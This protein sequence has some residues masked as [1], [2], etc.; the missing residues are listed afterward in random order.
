[1]SLLKCYSGRP[2][3][4]V[5]LSD[6][7]GYAIALAYRRFGGAVI[8]VRDPLNPE[9]VGSDITDL[10]RA[11]VDGETLLIM[12]DGPRGPRRKA[13][14]GLA[15]I[16]STTKATPVELDGSV[17]LRKPSLDRTVGA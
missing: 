5:A 16:A 4:L 6:E 9:R 2:P 12:P 7:R 11:V 1:M 14:G 10:A 13:R 17:Q 3:T 15:V 8:Q